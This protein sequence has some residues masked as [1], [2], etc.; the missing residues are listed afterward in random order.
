M[1]KFVL[2]LAVVA[3][4]VSACQNISCPLDNVV[5]LKMSMYSGDEKA[6]VLDTLTVTLEGRDSVLVNRI[7]NF[8]EVQLPLRQNASGV[9]TDTFLLHWSLATGEEGETPVRVTDTLTVRHG[10]TVHFESMDCPSSV[11][12]HLIDA[13][14]SRGLAD[15]VSINNP[16]VDYEHYENLRLYLSPLSE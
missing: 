1:R 9:V 13:T 12:H 2:I 10:C 16:A 15:S 5:M 6:R 4:C 7:Y 8:D 11:F 3:C 14:C